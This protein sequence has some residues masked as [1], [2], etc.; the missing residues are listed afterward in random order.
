MSGSN[1]NDASL[2]RHASIRKVR[3]AGTS[4]LYARERVTE[5]ALREFRFFIDY[6]GGQHFNFAQRV[7]ID[8]SVSMAFTSIRTKALETLALNVLALAC[9]PA[10]AIS[11]ASAPKL[12]R[13]FCDECLLG[14]PREAW[15]MPRTAVL[16]WMA[17]QQ[18]RVQRRSRR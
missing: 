6:N 15:S 11:G 12:V 5:G 16:E 17:T 10:S 7:W 4:W 13:T 14:A 3:R 9:H 1:K 8:P 2:G 18:R